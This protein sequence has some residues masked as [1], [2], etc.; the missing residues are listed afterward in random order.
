MRRY[1]FPR[2]LRA[3]GFPLDPRWREIAARNSVMD[4]VPYACGRFRASGKPV[5]GLSKFDLYTCSIAP[6]SAAVRDTES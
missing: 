3:L 2:G 1:F 5:T 6:G 4:G